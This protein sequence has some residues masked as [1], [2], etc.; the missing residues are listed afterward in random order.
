[1][2]DILL[3]R[4]TRVM[5]RERRPPDIGDDSVDL[6]QEEI[7]SKAGTH[8]TMPPRPAPWHAARAA[9]VEYS[10]VLHAHGFASSFAR[11]TYVGCPKS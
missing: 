9:K 2:G 11:P 1:M 4:D 6:H 3:H 8:D 7:D 5:L 10:T